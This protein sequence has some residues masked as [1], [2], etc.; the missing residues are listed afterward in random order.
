MDN[1][2]PKN[3]E[4]SRKA[5][6]LTGAHYTPDVLAD[7]VAKRMVDALLCDSK[8]APLEILDP[9]V[10]DGELLLSITRKLSEKGYTNIRV[11]GFDTNLD[12][13]NLATARIKKSFPQVSA[14]LKL[15]SFLDISAEHCNSHDSPSPGLLK[16][17]DLIIA[18]PPYVRTQVLGAERAQSLARQFNL[19]G[20]VDLYHAF[21]RGMAAV[22]SP[23]GTAG[24]IVSNRFM[25]TMSGVEVRSGI[26]EQFNI[27]HIWDLGDTKLFEAAVLPAILLL[28]KKD[29]ESYTSKPKFTSIYS[30]KNEEPTSQ[31]K[32][33]IAALDRNGVVEVSGSGRYLVRHG[34]L[35]NGGHPRGVWRIST[36]A[37]DTW[38]TTV[39]SYTH[40][41]FG[42]IGKIR[43]GV[44]T[45]A[46]KVFIRSDWHEM[47]ESQRPELL[48]PLTTHHVARRFRAMPPVKQILYPHQV[49]EGKRIAV[50][51]KD[52]PRAARYLHHHQQALEAR[53]YL[54]QAGRNW[55]E[56]WVPQ[57]PSLWAHPKIIFRDI[58]DKPIFW[59][60]LEGSVVNGDCYWL[61]GEKAERPELIWLAL[62][63]GN[64][65][66]IEAFY[67]HKFHNKLYSGRRRF[68]T[69]YVEQFPLPDPSTAIAK[70][71]IRAARDIYDLVPSSKAADSERS[72]D[73]L[74]WQAFGLPVEEVTR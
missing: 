2:I 15:G 39:Q 4:P 55:Y 46:D 47:P 51:L 24:V 54:A 21:I 73:Q 50:N 40:C 23:T 59:I 9:A 63:V 48:R 69:Q 33:V 20:R 3:A 58:T 62:A 61:V 71:I 7:F 49:V 66:F 16:K 10:G 28:R 32:N 22:L 13:I 53:E 64:S 52:F 70:K 27:L 45:T 44:K 67:D 36:E 26:A 19:S 18:N 37:S 42:D 8:T 38:L 35:D 68:M 65:S 30:A 25:T 17:F 6:K 72:L 74:V 31:C 5:R 14:I 11:N 60:D 29:G 56:I 12:A 34:K 57:D 41:T 43:V 1:L